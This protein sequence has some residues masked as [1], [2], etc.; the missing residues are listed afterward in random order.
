MCLLILLAVFPYAAV[1]RVPQS[2]GYQSRWAILFSAA[3]GLSI[4]ALDFYL[5]GSRFT[6]LRKVSTVLPVTILILF[7][8]KTWD[9]HGGWLQLSLENKAIETKLALVD[10]PGVEAFCIDT[11]IK[12]EQ[13]YQRRW[14]DWAYIF[15]KAWKDPNS[16]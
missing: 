1:G 4:A 5:R 10:P 7:S 15:S 2:I 6:F 13:L 14:Y 16:H 3:G 12:S 9:S 8:V 11:N